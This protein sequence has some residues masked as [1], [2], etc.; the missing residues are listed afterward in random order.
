MP[1][2]PLRPLRLLAVLAF[3]AVLPAAEPAAG[4]GL[5]DYS[6][7][8]RAQVPDA[9]KFNVGDLFKDP[10]AWRAEFEALARLAD[11]V[12]ALTNAWTRS[13]GSTAEMLEKV[14]E[15]HER[16]QRL[17]AYAR[18]QSDMDLSNPAYTRMQTEFQNLAVRFG[19]KTAFLA[20]DI[21]QLGEAQVAAYLTAEPRLAPYRFH[22][23]KALR[24]K[25]HTLS[26][27]EEGIV[28]QMGLFTDTAAK[29]SGLLNNVD[30][31]RAEV[32]LADGSKVLLNENNYLKYRISKN[33]GDRKTVVEAYWKNLGKYA[34]TFAA[35]LDGEMKKQVAVSRIYHYP[36]CLEATLFDNNISPEVYRNVITTVRANLAPLHRL[37]KLKQRMLGLPEL[38]YY[39]LPAPAVPSVT[40]VYTYEESQRHILAAMAP[41]GEAYTGG[42]QRAFDG[43]WIDLYPNK[44]K[45]SGGYSMGVYGMHPFIKMNYSGRYD[46]MSTLAHELGHSMHSALSNAAQ[47]FSTA[48][49]T[50]FIAEIAST[51]NEN[52]L[53]TEALN[54]ATDDR[55]KLRMLENFLERMRGTIYAQTLYADFE[56]AM[57]EQV[58]S[59]QPL[60]AEWLKAT[61][62]K[63]YR[64]YMGCD[65]GVV[66]A[67]DTVAV[68]WAAIPHFYR[69]FYVFQYVTGMV[70]ASALAEAVT[71]GGKPAADRYLTMLRAGGSKFP[72]DILRDAGVDM[73]QPAPIEAA[74]QRF[75]RL[76]AEMETLYAR[77]PQ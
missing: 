29:V 48:G 45:Q 74:I 36:G 63:S 49:Y 57:H 55:V 3:T 68:S 42:L 19:A 40:Q 69:P 6:Q 30:M 32:T 65:Q 77:L 46:D 76:V 24:N 2:H 60:T 47:P 43:H 11:S 5:P 58:E 20:P 41:L 12:D 8:E 1:M 44:G 7:T 61:F 72:L 33:A 53:F 16:G 21:L 39:D 62:E 66:K 70:A 64:L 15:F 27:K 14:H 52:L 38:N 25:D 31:P 59:G 56:L 28:A 54:A 18:L 17:H 73:S 35:L 13:P 34:N 26:E 23:E 51:F 10:A 37:F 9:F 50:T 71:R 4:P 67:D 22:L 75:D